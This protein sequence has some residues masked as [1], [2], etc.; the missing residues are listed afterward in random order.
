MWQNSESV[1]TSGTNTPK[2]SFFNGSF[3]QSLEDF[4]HILSQEDT[5]KFGRISEL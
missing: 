3:F 2:K 1:L 5:Q 4:S